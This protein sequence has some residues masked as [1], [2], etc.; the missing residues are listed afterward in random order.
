[1]ESGASVYPR[2]KQ[3]AYCDVIYL[4]DNVLTAFLNFKTLNLFAQKPK[5]NNMVTGEQDHLFSYCERFKV[6]QYN[7]WQGVE[8]KE[9]ETMAPV[10]TCGLHNNLLRGCSLA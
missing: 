5:H 4:V 9:L 8:L 6:K 7:G 1:M 3:I 2:T 10:W